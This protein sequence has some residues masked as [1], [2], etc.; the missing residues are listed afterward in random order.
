M[1]WLLCKQGEAAQAAIVCRFGNLNAPPLTVQGLQHVQLSVAVV[2][3]VHFPV[4]PVTESP[5]LRCM[6]HA[7]VY[8]LY[9][10]SAVLHGL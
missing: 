5:A 1:K 6:W 4:H 7:A 10:S 2:N 8:T 9:R 3:V